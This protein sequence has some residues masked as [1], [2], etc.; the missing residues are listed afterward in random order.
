MLWWRRIIL[1]S[2]KLCIIE[3]IPLMKASY[4]GFSDACNPKSF[5]VNLRTL[6]NQSAPEKQ[7]PGG[8]EQKTKFARSFWKLKHTD[9]T[10]ITKFIIICTESQS[11]C[12]FMS[13]FTLLL[14]TV[15]SKTV[16]SQYWVNCLESLWPGCRDGGRFVWVLSA[17][18]HHFPSWF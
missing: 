1:T 11:H 16:S 3:R 2:T 12:S 7:L 14:V 10:K 13:G 4:A 5:Y 17:G 8:K 6:W 9:I 18:C 15:C